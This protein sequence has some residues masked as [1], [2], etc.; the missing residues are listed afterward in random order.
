M[1]GNKG[2]ICLSEEMGRGVR[3]SH[4]RCMFGWVFKAAAAKAPLQ[5][6]F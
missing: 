3:T 4:R 6:V 2:V 5:A 1:S